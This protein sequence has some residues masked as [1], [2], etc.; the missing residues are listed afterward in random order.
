MVK[1]TLGPS[2]RELIMTMTQG[3]TAYGYFRQRD[4]HTTRSDTRSQ[5]WNTLYPRGG[6]SPMD[7]TKG[8]GG[9]SGFVDYFNG[10]DDDDDFDN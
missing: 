1:Q 5:I 6:P 4:V 3:L 10:S 2:P 8:K 9:S 7:F